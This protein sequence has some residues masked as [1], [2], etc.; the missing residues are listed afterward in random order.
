MDLVLLLEFTLVRYI[1]II[2]YFFS[3]GISILV[4]D[5]KVFC[6]SAEFQA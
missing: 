4:S 2:G 5:I 6:L 3:P 1:K